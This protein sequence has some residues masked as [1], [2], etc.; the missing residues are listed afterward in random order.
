MKENHTKMQLEEYPDVFADIVN[1][2]IFNGKSIVKPEDLVSESSLI[3]RENNKFEH[4][5]IQVWK[6]GHVRF[7][8]LL[9]R[10]LSDL[11]NIYH[12]AL[13]V[14]MELYMVVS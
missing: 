14:T 6:K 7:H 4:R 3:R 9:L 12:F 5:V 13:L 10:I 8:M 1:V 2:F 11:T